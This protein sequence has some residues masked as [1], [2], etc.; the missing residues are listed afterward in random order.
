MSGLESAG[1][2]EGPNLE[3]D[4]H[5]LVVSGLALEPTGQDQ[6]PEMALERR[7]IQGPQLA[8]QPGKCTAI[9]GRV[10]DQVSHDTALGRA[11]ESGLQLGPSSPE[12]LDDGFLGLGSGTVEWIGIGQCQ[13]E[14]A[15]M[16]AE[17]PCVSNEL[18]GEAD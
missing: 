5:A 7:E 4:R 13:L 3:L 8:P 17:Q 9:V 18:T 11:L 2:R 6:I 10:V 1:K 12:F 14:R 16:I 15:L